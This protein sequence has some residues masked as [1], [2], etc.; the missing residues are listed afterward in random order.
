MVAIAVWIGFLG[1]LSAVPLIVLLLMREFVQYTRWNSKGVRRAIDL[2][3]V[4]L[5]F[6]FWCGVIL[7][8]HS[9]A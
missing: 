5:A 8:F 6:L 9:M 3:I 7:L 1:Q 2:A 4:P